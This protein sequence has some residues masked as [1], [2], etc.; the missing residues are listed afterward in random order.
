MIGR[1]DPRESLKKQNLR[2][3]VAMTATLVRPMSQ[4]V[5]DA[6]QYSELDRELDRALCQQFLAIWLRH[7]GTPA[8]DE[9]PLTFEMFEAAADRLALHAL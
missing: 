4:T 8:M 2:E 3:E 9:Q 1:A 5:V 7:Q 6:P